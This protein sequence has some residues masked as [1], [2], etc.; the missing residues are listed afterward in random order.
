MA[1]KPMC[2]ICGEIN[3]SGSSKHL[4]E[5]E[6][7]VMLRQIEILTGVWLDDLPNMPEHICMPCQFDL[8]QAVAFRK[9]CISTQVRLFDLVKTHTSNTF[10]I[11]EAEADITGTSDEEININHSTSEHKDDEEDE[12]KINNPSPVLSAE[13]VSESS[14]PNE[15]LTKNKPRTKRDPKKRHVDRICDQCGRHFRDITNFKLH[16]LRH[17]G[18][19]SFECKLCERK[20]YTNHLLKMHI[21]TAHDGERP[22]ICRLENCKRKFNDN[23]SRLAHERT[24]TRE[25]PYKCMYCEK[26]FNKT[27]HRTEHQRAHTGERPYKCELCNLTFQRNYQLTQHERSQTHKNK[28]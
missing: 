1:F 21:R 14:K 24:H 5:N 4:F 8:D 17:T 28:L 19:K 18:N 13:D 27:S 10:I 22:F 15:N 3:Y 6:A 23:S 20:Y 12:N 2:R 16:L 25:Y 7:K 26:R 11:D 9:R